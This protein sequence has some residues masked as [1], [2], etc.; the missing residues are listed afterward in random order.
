[1]NKGFCTKTL[2][3][4][5]SVLSMCML[6][7]E[8]NFVTGHL[9]GALRFWSLKNEKKTHEIKDYHSEAITSVSIT[10]NGRYMLT[11]SRDHSMKL[12]DMISF[13][14]LATFEHDLL[15]N[16][17][18][19]QK[20]CI[21][22]NGRFGI[23]GSKNGNVFIVQLNPSSIELEEIYQE[24]PSNVIACEWQPE[25]SKFASYD[26]TGNMVIWE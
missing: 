23:A 3:A 4:T 12:L 8:S 22:S 17:S 24:H 7:N 1:M 26:M 15:M 6:P 13:Q 14:C 11:Y 16:S 2:A 10:P 5:S 9:D 19:S 25:G 18:P 21:S 20:A